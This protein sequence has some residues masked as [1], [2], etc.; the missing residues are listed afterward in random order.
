MHRN[1]VRWGRSAVPI[2]C[3]PRSS[4]AWCLRERDRKPIRAEGDAPINTV[5]QCPAVGQDSF[6]RL[7]PYRDRG[8]ARPAR[9]PGLLPTPPPQ[10]RTH[11]VSRVGP[12]PF[13]ADD[14]KPTHTPAAWMISLARP[15]QPNHAFGVD[16]GPLILIPISSPVLRVGHFSRALPGHSCQAPKH[17]G[18]RG[19]VAAG[20]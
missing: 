16:D 13:A 12:P 19:L 5:C 8:S 14:G 1:R 9:Q 2:E 11:R 20:S 18:A 6:A 15:L 7:F 3:W 4:T 10:S 17:G